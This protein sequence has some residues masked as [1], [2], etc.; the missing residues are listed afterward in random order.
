MSSIC[1]EATMKKPHAMLVAVVAALAMSSTP[2]I[3]QQVSNAPARES[4][5]LILT[6]KVPLTGVSGRID[7]FTFDPK[8]RL[9]IF[10]GLGNNTVEIVNNFQGKHVKTIMGLNE[11]QGPLYVPGLDKLFVANAGNGVVDVYDAKTW[12]LRKSISLGDDSDTDNLRY[13]EAA[14][15]VLVGMMGGIAVIDALTEAHVGDLK[16]S[17]GH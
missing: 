13:D 17:G 14:K 10:S 1:S 11:P 2:G 8:R 16:G 5:T 4:P 9:T 7:H 12:N 6:A 3:S 15:Q